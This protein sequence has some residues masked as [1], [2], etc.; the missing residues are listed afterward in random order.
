MVAS[1]VAFILFLLDLSSFINL[2]AYSKRGIVFITLI[3]VITSGIL[4]ALQYSRQPS[5][6]MIN[7]CRSIM[8]DMMIKI[9]N[10]NVNLTTFKQDQSDIA[11]YISGN[12]LLL[13]EE[14]LYQNLIGSLRMHSA[15][16]ETQLGDIRGLDRDIEILRKHNFPV[17]LITDV[18][19]KDL[20]DLETSYKE[21]YDQILSTP[22][23]SIRES[24][25][26]NSLE[27]IYRSLLA[28]TNV[29]Y[30]KFIL[31]VQNMPEETRAIFVEDFAEHLENLPDVLSK[32]EDEI[33]DLIK[34]EYKYFNN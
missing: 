31:I 24:G 16:M 2:R 4:L 22:A 34:S 15:Q 33:V 14:Y 21:Y 1:V 19:G 8:G 20:P 6:P 27:P 9:Q 5:K 12:R 29:I 25:F 23:N 32:P 7:A 13:S 18:Y 10:T 17:Q 28:R 11:S 3:C 30:Y 26:R